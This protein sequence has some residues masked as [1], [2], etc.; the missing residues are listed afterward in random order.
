MI[1]KIIHYCWFGGGEIPEADQK[2]IESW[3]KHCPDYKIILWNE[4]NYDISK[5]KYMLDAYNSK[6]WG[7]VPDYARLDI[8]Y[9]YGGIYL[10]TDVELLK[11]LDDLLENNAFMGREKSNYINPGLGFGAIPHHEGIGKLLHIYDELKFIKE[12]GSFDLIP[13]PIRNTEFLQQFG[14][15]LSEEFQEILDI[16]VYP[17]EYFCPINYAT[18]EIVMCPQTYSIHHYSMSWVDPIIRKWKLREQKFTRKIG[19]KNAKRIVRILSFPDRVVHKF[20]V[21]GIKKTFSFIV[22]KIER[23]NQ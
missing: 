12:D 13:S 14:A 11:N 2:C 22:K 3:K 8:I 7:F 4:S 1:P 16:S 10:D 19:R 23:R 17:S 5:N 15:V 9:N 18:G 6:K 21:L 20:K